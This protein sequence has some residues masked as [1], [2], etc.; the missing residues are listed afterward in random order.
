MGTFMGLAVPL[1]SDSGAEIM[2]VSTTG[3]V[4]FLTTVDLSLNVASSGVNGIKL[5]VTSTG[6]IAS[7]GV[8]PNGF[9]VAGSSKSVLNTAFAYQSG[10]GSAPAD[11]AIAFLGVSGT[12]HPG[13]FLS[14]GGSAGYA[15]GAGNI[16]SQASGLAGGMF[17]Q[18]SSYYLV[19]AL[20]TTMPIASLRVLA[21]S[22]VFF[23]PMLTDTMLAAA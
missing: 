17:C 1:F 21:G 20:G 23:I 15:T 22:K 16:N 19:S 11:T 18:S 13:A 3:A 5:S 4:T 10:V 7:G 14:I 12:M 2:S 8:F 6:A 9:V